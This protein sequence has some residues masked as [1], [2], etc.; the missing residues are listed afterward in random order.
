[1]GGGRT[2]KDLENFIQVF[3]KRLKMDCLVQN[4]RKVSAIHKKP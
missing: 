2:F 3:P 4:G 1:M